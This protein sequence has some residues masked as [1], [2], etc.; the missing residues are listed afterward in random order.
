MCKNKGVF[1]D[2]RLSAVLG[3]ATLS[4]TISSSNSAISENH[5]RQKHARGQPERE[6]SHNIAINF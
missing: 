4:C 3:A 2:L 5:C 1:E 6:Q